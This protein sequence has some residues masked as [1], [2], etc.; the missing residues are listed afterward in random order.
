MHGMVNKVLESSISD[1]YGTDVWARVTE[2]AGVDVDFFVEMMSYPDDITYA[3]VKAACDELNV[4]G[5]QFLEWF[6]HRW[7]ESTSRGSYQQYYE[8]ATDMLGF[9]EH[10]NH[11]HQDLAHAMPDLNTPTF[12]LLRSEDGPAVLEY[13]TERPGLTAFVVGLLLGLADHYG[14]TVEIEVAERREDNGR[15]DVFRILLSE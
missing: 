10:L 15:A 8:M 4:S 14:Q 9:L 7:I 5:D 11:L 6:G 12:R 1:E 3:I 2:R 13:F